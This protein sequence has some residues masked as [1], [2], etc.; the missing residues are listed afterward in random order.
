MTDF[1]GALGSAQ[2]DKLPNFIHKRRENWNK[3]LTLAK[4]MEDFFILPFE[5]P[6]T[7]PSWYG[8]A[9]TIKPNLKLDRT[10]LLRYL[11]E[12]KIGTRLLFAGDLTR[13]PSFRNQQYRVVGELNN[14]NLITKNTFWIGCWP[15]LEQEHLEFMITTIHN[16]AKKMFN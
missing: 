6:I 8:F 4:Q 15:G 14:T 11:S 3:L 12:K 1:Q 13:Q 7:Q 16:Y 9:L 10:N 5:D 2:M